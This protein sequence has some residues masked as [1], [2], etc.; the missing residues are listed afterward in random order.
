MHC[1]IQA[2]V[3]YFD[4][5]FIRNDEETIVLDKYTNSSSYRIGFTI[6]ESFVTPTDDS[7]LNDNATGSSNESAT[8]PIDLK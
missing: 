8:V 6:T 7:S 4:G 5:F 3:Y 1:T 2:G